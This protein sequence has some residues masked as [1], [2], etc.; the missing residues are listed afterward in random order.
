[1]PSD[2][3]FLSSKLNRTDLMFVPLRDYF[4]KETLLQKRSVIHENSPHET[5]K[6]LWLPAF[7]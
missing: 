5:L 4:L 6:H 2:F 3:S 1:M 7:A